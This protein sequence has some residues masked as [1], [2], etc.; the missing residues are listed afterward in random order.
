[1]GECQCDSIQLKW[2]YLLN[3]MVVVYV[4][5]YK[6]VRKRKRMWAW[7]SK[8]SEIYKCNTDSGDGRGIFLSLSLTIFLSL[9]HNVIQLFCFCRW[10]R[11]LNT[12]MSHTQNHIIL[13]SCHKMWYRY[14]ERER[15]QSIVPVLC[16]VALLLGFGGRSISA[17]KHWMSPGNPV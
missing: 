17:R 6:N 2:N 14:R 13:V 9:K 7:K 3:V 10:C 11:F 12:R 4:F 1:M 5:T 15:S 8:A 16:F